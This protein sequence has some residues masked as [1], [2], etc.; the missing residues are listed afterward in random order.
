MIRVWVCSSVFIVL[1]FEMCIFICVL[2]YM[3]LS[4]NSFRFSSEEKDIISSHSHPCCFPDSWLWVL[5]T[6]HLWR[7]WPMSLHLKSVWFEAGLLWLPPSGAW[8]TLI[9][10]A[11]TK[12]VDQHTSG[13]LGWGGWEEAEGIMSR[14]KLHLSTTEHIIKEIKPWAF[15]VGALIPRP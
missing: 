1:Y 12:Q 2:S 3:C 8:A 6:W 15:G 13:Y 4:S 11:R 10:K 7:E 14:R 5:W 9:S